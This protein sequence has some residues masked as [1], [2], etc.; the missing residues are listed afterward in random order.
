VERSGKNDSVGLVING[1]K[2]LSS[3]GYSTPI[4]VEPSRNYRVEF[5]MK[6][7]MG[8]DEEGGV[9]YLEYD[10]LIPTRQ[11]LTQVE[12]ARHIVG[13]EDS[14][15]IKGEHGWKKFTF[16]FTTGPESEMVHVFFYREGDPGPGPLIFDDI[17]IRVIQ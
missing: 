14:V 15:R 13:G 17:S 2:G 6:S 10:T 1:I 12:N 16:D 8:N 3:V 4:I 5:W 7:G 9:G 11:Q